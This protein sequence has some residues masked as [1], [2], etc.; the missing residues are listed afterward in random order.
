MPD[1]RYD[2]A[3]IPECSMEALMRY[4]EHHILPGIFLRAV[5]E[6]DLHRAYR[7]ADPT[8]LWLLPIYAAWLHNEAPMQCYG[9]P[10]LV[11][12][13]VEQGHSA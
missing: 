4:T 12:A 9:S 6:G 11:R 2:Y 13:W 5:L 1:S 8:N 3:Q 10:E 7:R